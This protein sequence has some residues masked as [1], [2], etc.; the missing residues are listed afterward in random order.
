MGAGLGDVGR[1]ITALL[2]VLLTM[3]TMNM[4]VAAG[5]RL[6][7][8]LAQE[9][10]APAFLAAPRYALGAM[11]LLVGVLMVPLALEAIDPDVL[12]RATSALF[13][14]VYV[15]ATAAGSRL[16]DGGPRVAS[17]VSLVAV[18]VVFAFSGAYIL[19]PVAILALTRL[20]RRA[21]P[22]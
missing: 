22:V 17:S 12:M 7:G 9:G 8:A 20:A 11:A 14:A 15:L 4:Y 21:V 2:A 1:R 5:S 6:A 10:N 16:L 3:G 19:V 18:A 13:I